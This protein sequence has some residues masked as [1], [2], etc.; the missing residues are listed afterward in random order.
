[1]GVVYEAEDTRLGR[2]VAL[3]FLPPDL[4]GDREALQRFLREA[5]AAAA[6][7]HPHICTIHEIDQHDGVHFIVMELLEGSTLKHRVGT[8]P[9]ATDEVLNIG[10]QVA[11]GLHAAH[12]HG[13]AH[14]DI[15]PANIFAT[16]GGQ[17]KILDFGLAKLLNEQAALAEGATVSSAGM[18]TRPGMA[19]GTVGFMSPEQVRGEPLDARTDLFSLG[20]VLYEMATGRQAFGGTTTGTVFDKILHTSPPPPLRLNPE[21][22]QRLEEIIQKALEK[23]RDLRYHTAAELAADLKRLKRDLESARLLAQSV[24]VLSRPAR[25]A[26]VTLFF[27]AVL[28][29]AVLGLL[30]WRAVTSPPGV[31]ANLSQRALTANASENPVYAAAISPDGKYLAYADFTGVFLR[32][33]DTGET[34]R[35][36]LPEGFC[37]R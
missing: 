18:I 3:K 26:S 12:E 28:L 32:L 29:L 16:K 2:H 20:A 15:K 17:A 11:D 30:L 24:P 5:R 1:M 4:T 9:L 23:D 10:I 7:N 25:R 19:L 6:L 33:L 8:Q 14:R 31:P 35:V 27:V 36:S 34:H 13:I 22:P 21:I 37:F